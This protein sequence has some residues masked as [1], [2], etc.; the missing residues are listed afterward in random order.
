MSELPKVKDLCPKCTGAFAL[1]GRY[2]C[3]RMLLTK[4][5]DPEDDAPCRRV[6]DDDNKEVQKTA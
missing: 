5:L 3:M 4:I 1:Y 2:V 6:E